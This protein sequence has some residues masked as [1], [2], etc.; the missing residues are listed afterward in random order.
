MYVTFKICVGEDRA[1][2][3][4]IYV[5]LFKVNVGQKWKMLKNNAYFSITI[6]I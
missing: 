2:R 3:N 4:K 1:L 6:K 5:F